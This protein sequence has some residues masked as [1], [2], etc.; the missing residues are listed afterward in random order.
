MAMD[1]KKIDNHSVALHTIEI[2]FAA[3]SVCKT[4]PG[5]D[6]LQ[7]KEQCF[8]FL[9]R[10]YDKL[11][12]KRP[13]VVQ[14]IHLSRSTGSTQSI[15]QTAHVSAALEVFVETRRM[16]PSVAD[17]VKRDYEALCAK[18]ICTYLT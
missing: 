1:F 6:I 17:I 5:V 18:E 14:R 13:L 10:L 15:A 3:S 2:E 12:K 7:F 11:M 9:H 16:T 4:A 8:F